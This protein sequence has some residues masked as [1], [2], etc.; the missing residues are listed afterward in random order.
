MKVESSE[1]K[2][3]QCSNSKCGKVI[4]YSDP[5]VRFGFH[6]PVFCNPCAID[7]LSRQT[8]PAAGVCPTSTAGLAKSTSE[9]GLTYARTAG[10][11]K[12]GVYAQRR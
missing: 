8:R 5:Y 3:R 1:R 9:T 4:G 10:M 12:G 11:D 6:G 7:L 2:V